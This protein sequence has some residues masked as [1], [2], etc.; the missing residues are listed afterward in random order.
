MDDDS[1][2]DGAVDGEDAFPL[3]GSE[4]SDNDEDGIGDNADMM[5]IMTDWKTGQKMKSAVI[6]STPIQTMMD[7]L[8]KRN[9]TPAQILVSDGDGIDDDNDPFV[10]ANETVDTDGDGIGDNTDTD[11][12]GDGLVDIYE[13]NGAKPLDTDTVEWKS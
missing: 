4:T 13:I 5:T 2:D 3:D 9:I 10:D 11:D 6:R 7:Y 12:D 1:D 8:M